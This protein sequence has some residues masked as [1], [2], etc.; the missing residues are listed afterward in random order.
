MCLMAERLIDEAVYLGR[1]ECA[2]KE[3]HP[4]AA[5]SLS[6][7]VLR[8]NPLSV[9]ALRII[10]ASWRGRQPSRLR[11]SLVQPWLALMGRIHGGMPHK[12]L[13]L[14]QRFLAA[15]VSDACVYQ[16]L[17][18]SSC[19]LEAW[20]VAR[21]AYEALVK[22]MPDSQDCSLELARV[23]L[24]LGDLQSALAWADH[25]LAQ[26]PAHL[27]AQALARE[28]AVRQAMEHTA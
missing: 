16:S 24:V 12:R 3:G 26:A 27:E 23:C 7:E 15:G 4:E 2:L 1:A 25:I 18:E 17:A 21:F 14:A 13:L 5:L 10:E 22:K 11:R 9:G 8:A 28:A 20:P 6:N 19:V